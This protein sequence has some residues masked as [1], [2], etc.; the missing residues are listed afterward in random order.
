MP[1]IQYNRNYKL[2]IGDARTTDA[3][4]ITDLQVSFDISKSSDNTSRTNSASIEVTNLSDNSLKILQTDYPAALFYVGYQDDLKLLFG[5]Q[6]VNV[7][8]RKSGT[9]RVTQLLMGSGYNELNHST[10]AKVVPANK[11]VKDIADEIAKSIPNVSRVVFNGTNLNNK[12]IK[13]YPISGTVR[14][15]LDKLSEA[16]K[17]EWRLDSDV[18]YVNDKDR[19]ENEDFGNA[20]VVSPESG[21][22]EIPYYTS[23]DIT[24]DS[25]DSV[26]KQGV[27]FTMLINPDVYP[28]QIIKLEDTDIVGW[29]K[30]DDVRYSGSYRNGTWQQDVSCSAIE[31]VNKQ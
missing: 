6:V 13:G 4:E 30:V 14:E 18:L 24:R 9:D 21:L 15:A 19:A 31:K 17:L 25:S 2:V 5:G 1:T 20:Y 22:I 7:R 27:Q 8:T 16:Y 23:G 28:G 29:F 12:V 10:I 26:K 11:T 3:L